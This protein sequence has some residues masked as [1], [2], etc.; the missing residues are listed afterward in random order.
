MEKPIFHA[1][2]DGLKN[3]P[4]LS[5]RDILYTVLVQLS[6]LTR[7]SVC[8]SVADETLVEIN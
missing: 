3:S 6:K 5:S 1:I 2:V 8:L 4:R 7:L